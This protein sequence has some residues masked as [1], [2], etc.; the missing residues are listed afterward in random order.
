MRPQKKIPKTMVVKDD[1]VDSRTPSALDPMLLGGAPR[2][3]RMSEMPT[4][5]SRNG[6][7]AVPNHRGPKGVTH[8]PTAHVTRNKTRNTKTAA[9]Q[10][11]L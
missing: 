7:Q 11:P 1:S 5:T 8:A 2:A 3:K 6:S 10:P 9:G 4:P